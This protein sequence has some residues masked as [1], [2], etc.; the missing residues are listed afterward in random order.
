MADI[1]IGFC[2]ISFYPFSRANKNYESDCFGVTNAPRV[3]I[4]R[5][6]IKSERRDNPMKKSARN[7]RRQ[8]VRGL[9]ESMGF[10][11]RVY[12]MRDQVPRESSS[13]MYLSIYWV[14]NVPLRDSTRP[15][16]RWRPKART[17]RRKRESSHRGTCVYVF[18]EKEGKGDRDWI[19]ARGLNAGFKS[20]PYI[21]LP[22]T[23][24]LL[25]A[26]AS[27]PCSRDI[28]LYYFCLSLFLSLFLV[29]SL[30]IAH[31]IRYELPRCEE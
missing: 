29:L 16:E 25:S 7:R 4:T 2:Y 31:A 8:C 5:R 24:I 22:D 30:F 6:D 9:K 19:M 27:R 13:D 3:E 14:S 12:I 26:A 1:K 11:I 15:S 28:L 20:I 23:F 17:K 10:A 21:T 18:V